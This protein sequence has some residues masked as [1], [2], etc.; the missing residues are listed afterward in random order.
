MGV[1]DWFENR[2]RTREIERDME[3]RRGKIQVRRHIDRQKQMAKKLYQLG[4]RALQL[5]DERQFQVLGK[6]YLWTLQEIKR[7]ER[8]LLTIEAI[9]ARRDQARAIA[10]FLN[11]VQAMSK[12]ILAVSDP[13]RLA[14]HQREL[15]LAIAR[16]ED[17]EQRLD[18]ILEMTD[19]TVFA[20][21]MPDEELARSLKELEH[22]ML[23]AEATDEAG[24]AEEELDSR[25]EAALR[26]IEEQMR[27]DS[28]GAG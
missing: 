22:E 20:S 27:K 16:A 6:Q 17:M 14:Q 21:E 11:S 1:L 18:L 15:E 8:F 19:E 4:R 26:R 3:A 24:T 7:G 23:Q 12:S 13:K 28:R 9:E 25:I 2:R 5:G 10:E